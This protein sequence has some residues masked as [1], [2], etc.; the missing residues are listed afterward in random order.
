MSPA[1]ELCFRKIHLQTCSCCIEKHYEI[2]TDASAI[3][4]KRYAI[5]KFITGG[6]IANPAKPV[7]GQDKRL[8]PPLT[9]ASAF[10]GEQTRG[11][12]KNCCCPYTIAQYYLSGYYSPCGTQ[13]SQKL[14]LPNELTVINFLLNVVPLFWVY[15][16]IFILLV[17]VPTLPSTRFK[18][19][20]SKI[21]PRVS[22]GSI[23][24]MPLDCVPTCPSV[25]SN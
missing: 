3:P 16:N 12:S 10:A 22:D 17:S 1:L 20:V 8:R 25:R 21:W 14:V 23:I 5:E 11:N 6:K 9:A 24:F 13:R 18:S 15:S 4:Q 2:K 7:N 19:S